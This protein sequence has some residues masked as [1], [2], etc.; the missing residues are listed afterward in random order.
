MTW[1]V[2]SLLLMLFFQILLIVT[3]NHDTQEMLLPGDALISL[4]SVSGKISCLYFN[5]ERRMIADGV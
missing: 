5:A 2:V 1:L 4:P 3:K